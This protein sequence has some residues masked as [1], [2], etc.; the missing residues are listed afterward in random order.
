[1]AESSLCHT[2]IQSRAKQAMSGLAESRPESA[3]SAPSF[4]R[5]ALSVMRHPSSSQPGT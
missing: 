4:C 5:P 3:L 2:V 1:M